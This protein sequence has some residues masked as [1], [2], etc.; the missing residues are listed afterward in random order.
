MNTFKFN[1]DIYV[2]GDDLESAKSNLCEEMDY[3]CGLDN[4]II[5]ASY[6]DNGVLTERDGMPIKTDRNL[7]MARDI[8]LAQLALL[9]AYGDD[10]AGTEVEVEMNN[11]VVALCE[12]AGLDLLDDG[13]Y[14]LKATTDEIAAY[15]LGRINPAISA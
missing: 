6:D 15:N 1:V 12:E 3:L 13:G 7:D 4:P 11:S 10:F 14:C 5:A 9:R 2:N 8:V